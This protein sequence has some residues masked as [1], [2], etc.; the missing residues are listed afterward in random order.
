MKRETAR[1]ALFYLGILAVVYASVV[2]FGYTLH[3]TNYASHGITDTGPYEHDGRLPIN[4]FN[5]N[6]ANSSYTE[7]PNNV[8]VGDMY[9]SGELP[10]WN[11]YQAAGTPLAAQ[12][13]TRA[14]FPYQIVED[15]SP[16]WTWD[17]FML[18]R[19]WLAGFFTFLFLRALE[20][21][22]ASALLGGLFFM[23]SGT[24]VWFIHKEEFVNVAMMAPI[25]LWSIERLMS[26][27]RA[28]YFLATMFATAL[29]LLAGQPEAA[30]FVLLLGG[31]YTLYRIGAN[32]GLSWSGARNIGVVAAA[33]VLGLGLSAPLLLP[34]QELVGLSFHIHQAGGVMGVT[35]PTPVSWGTGMVLPTFF[36]MPT[37]QR[38]LPQNGVWDFLGGYI[39]VLPVF[40]III[41]LL[42]RSRHRGLL[43]FFLICGGWI[44]LKSFGVPPFNLIGYLPVLDQVWSNLWA[45]PVWTFSLAV[46]GALGYEAM[47]QSREKGASN[48]WPWLRNWDIL[49]GAGTLA[50][51]LVAVLFSEQAWELYAGMIPS[52]AYLLIPYSRDY[53]V[54]ST[55]VGVLVAIAVLTTAALLWRLGTSAQGRQFAI[56]AL[57]A[58]ALWFY[59]PRGYNYQFIYLKLIPVGLGI[60]LVW[61]LMRERWRWA[62]S[63]LV[64]AVVVATGIDVVAPNGFPK[65]Q[66]PFQPAPYVEYIKEHADYSRVMATDGVL[67]PNIAGALGIYDIRYINSINIASYHYYMRCLRGLVPPP[68]ELPPPSGTD[69][70]FT[71]LPTFS[72]VKGMELPLPPVIEERLPYY[73][74]LGVKYIITPSSV[75]IHGLPLVYENEVN[76]YENPDALP[77]AFVAYQLEYAP[78]FEA[79]QEMIGQPDFAWEKTVVL[80]EEA[81]GRYQN[82]SGEEFSEASIIDYQPN[83]LTIEVSTKDAGMLVLSD[84]YFPG[85]EARVD[86]RGAK[87]YRVNGV[88]RGVFI[89]PGTHSVE[90]TY[91]ANSFRQ[92]V[93]IATLSLLVG[94]GCFLIMRRRERQ[95]SSTT[96]PSDWE[97]WQ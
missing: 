3:A 9:R 16:T 36:D 46:A 91:F 43:I 68:W 55:Q 44:L 74:V 10:L 13:S 80:E 92:G 15:I 89:E 72:Y 27:R 31:V 14:F 65:R 37:P 45:G 24:M 19:L 58:T 84:N 11:P 53:M 71:G 97:W 78:S 96:S 83:Q 61:A 75:T 87:I 67:M 8:V 86:G 77:R 40:L 70:W 81:P 21:R 82:L 66:D 52:R 41:G 69:L 7:F 17:F 35:D 12:Y 63:I 76:I 23:F 1:A 85:W 32:Y 88:M 25:F 5:T 57:A 30:V 59:I 95:E 48:R 90:F 42:H 51:I 20:L 26:S 60:A 62:V 47:E 93:V 79:A 2:F 4:T 73:S 22:F 28:I 64:V 29:I 54:A 49:V 33:F 18:G 6:L 56:L 39:G 34:F 94:L 50:I 38:V